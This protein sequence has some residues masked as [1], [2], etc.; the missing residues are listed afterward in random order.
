MATIPPSA[1]IG[2]LLL[3]VSQSLHS[4]EEVY[5]A[6]W[7]V[8]A[9]ARFVSGLVSEDLAVGFA[10]LNSIIVLLG[11]W[12]YLIPVRQSARAAM[13]IMWFWVVLELG[14]SIGHSLLAIGADGYF[15]GVYTAPLLFVAAFF[16]GTKLVQAH[17]HSVSTFSVTPKEG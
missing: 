10:V 17:R 2:F 16:V 11:L 13:A 3:I 5:F 1:K 12:C 15:P 6:L 7:E 14:N 4:L 9:P 8:W